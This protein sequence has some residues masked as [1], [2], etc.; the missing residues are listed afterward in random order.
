MKLYILFGV[1]IILIVILIISS[2]QKNNDEIN[3]EIK[4]NDVKVGFQHFWGNYLTDGEIPFVNNLLSL[5]PN[6][7]HEKDLSK[8]NII[9]HSHFGHSS[10]EEFLPNVKYIF[11][12]GEHFNFDI[13]N[14]NASLSNQVTSDINICYP[15][16][17]IF[18]HSFH[19][20]IKNAYH[21]DKSYIA[22]KFCAFI[23]S[24]KSFPGCKVRNEFFH[25]LTN[26]YKKVLSYGKAFNNV[27]YSL[28][29]NYYDEKQ[30]KLLNQHKFVICFEN[31]KTEDYYITEKLFSAKF[32]GS[33]PIYW[34]TKKCLEIFNDDAFL[35]LEDETEESFKKLKDKI[36]ELD[37]NDEMYLRMRNN[38]LFKQEATSKFDKSYIKAL[39]KE[40]L[41]L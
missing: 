22:D 4:K 15:F 6:S 3:D 23:A 30:L 36:I 40:K 17:F 26:N 8:C 31:T 25:Y 28:D 19:D 11:F 35:Y 24:N 34:G 16:F 5:I 14:Y 21:T 13:K 38:E 10:K 9:F 33:I 27:G 2:I 18:Y 37:N 20:R 41:N 39:I 32:S 7:V 29:F 12:S 1:L